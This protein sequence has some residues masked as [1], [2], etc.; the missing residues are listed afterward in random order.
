[1]KPVEWVGSSRDDLRQFPEPVRQEAGH[2]LYLAQKGEKTLNA[3]PLVGFGGAKV[4]EVVMNEDGDAYRAV[5][6][7]KFAK[8]VYV[9]HAF[10][11]KSRKGITTP[12]PDLQLIRIRLSAAAAH[13]ETN[14]E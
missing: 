2:S 1:M 11:K 8:A 4:L 9:L 5:Y 6:T 13:Y 14:Y 7:V 3:K 10:Q 12:R